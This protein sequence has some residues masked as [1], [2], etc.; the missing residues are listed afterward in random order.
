MTSPTSNA[1]SS[2][3]ALLSPKFWLAPYALVVSTLYLWGYWGTFDINVL[4][5]IGLSD[6]VKAAVYPILSSFTALAIG[7]LMGEVLSPR[8]EPGGGAHTPIAKFVRKLAPVLAIAYL[9]LFVGIALYGGSIKWHL[10]PTLIAL[11]VYLPVKETDLLAKEIPADGLRSII[12]FLLILLGPYAYGHGRLE[13]DDVIQGNKYRAVISA[14]PTTGL[15]ASRKAEERSRFVGKLGDRFAVYDPVAH[16]VSLIAASELKVLTMAGSGAA[17]GAA[18]SAPSEGTPA[19]AVNS[20]SSDGR[21]LP[22]ASEAAGALDG[23]AVVAAP[24]SASA[25]LVT[26]GQ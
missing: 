1:G 16:S 6:V 11:L 20:T 3:S 4:D 21:V 10:L 2:T 13:A 22:R 19:S 14:L 26:E 9:I 23:A 5:Y 18:A 25:S 15:V 7:A 24:P 12:I 8:I 17:K